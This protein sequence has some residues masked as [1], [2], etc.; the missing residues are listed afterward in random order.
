MRRTFLMIALAMAV[1]T[2]DP[3]SAR[4]DRLVYYGDDPAGTVA[5]SLPSTTLT[6]DVEAIRENYYAGP[7]AQ[8][9]AKYLGIDVRT[10]DEVSYTLSSVSLTP[11][12][13]ADLSRR[14]LLNLRGEEAATAFLKLTASGLVS[15]A[16]SVPGSSPAWKFPVIARENYSDKSLTANLTTEAAT[17]YKSVRSESAYDRISMQ[18]DMV[19]EKTEEERAAEIAQMIFSLR[20]QRMSIITGDTD[21]SYSGSAMGAALAEISRLEQEYLSLFIGYSEY[22]TQKV[23]LDLVPTKNRESQMYVAFR[24]SETAG[25]LPAE[26]VSGKP[27]AV[28]IIPEKIASPQTGKKKA[29]KSKVPVIVYRIPATCSVRVL[30]GKNTLMQARIPVYQFGEETTLPVDL[31]LK[32][33]DNK[34]VAKYY[35]NLRSF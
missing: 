33:Q 23:T 19:V 4:K 3:A 20:E 14:Y 15:S 18:H 26:S 35:E 24:F 5:Y 27:V 29:R 8:Y 22:G 9:A 21:A 1:L 12:A 32:S 25:I 2:A 16:E 31:V 17:L 34:A 28:E 7:Y 10:A 11:Y 6:I 13:E 30:D